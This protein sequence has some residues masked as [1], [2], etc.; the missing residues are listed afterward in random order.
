MSS[1]PSS[2]SANALVASMLIAAITA[3]TVQSFFIVVLPPKYF[4]L[5]RSLVPRTAQLC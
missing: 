1:V 2:L 4:E 3:I 5:V